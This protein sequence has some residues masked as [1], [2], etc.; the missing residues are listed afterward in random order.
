MTDQR[1]ADLTLG[2][3]GEATYDTEQQ[4]WHFVRQRD[5][6]MYSRSER[7]NPD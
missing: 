6:G 7:W 1:A 4:Q 5:D 2:Q 3:L